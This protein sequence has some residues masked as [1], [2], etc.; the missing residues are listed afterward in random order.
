MFCLHVSFKAMESL[1]FR[2]GF[3]KHKFFIPLR[4]SYIQIVYVKV[5]YGTQ[6]VDY[7]IERQRAWTIIVTTNL[8]I[9]HKSNNENTKK[10]FLNIF[11]SLCLCELGTQI[12]RV[13]FGNLKYI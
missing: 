10:K 6:T 7:A 9:N 3:L 11:Q 13:S 5:N 2:V 12:L 8:K 4:N 1:S